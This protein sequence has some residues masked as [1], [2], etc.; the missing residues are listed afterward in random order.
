[1]R[2]RSNVPRGL[3]LVLLA[4]LALASGPAGGQAPKRGGILNA[5]LAEDP[6]GFS[7]HE[8]STISGVWPLSPCYS[9]LVLFD[10]LKPHESAETVVPELAERWSWQD[11]YR[12]L[13]FFLRKNVRW[14]DGQPFSAKDVKYTF[15]VVREA[16][17]APAKGGAFVGPALMSPP[18]G[19]W[20]L[21]DKELKALPGY[22]AAA[23]DK[24]EARRLL[25]SAGVAPGTLLKVDLVTRNFAIY[26]D[27]ASFVVDQLKQIGVEATLR[28][29]D[30][31]AWFPTL[32]RREFQIGANLTAGVVDDPDAY[33]FENYKCGSP[34]NYTDYCD[35]QV[36]RLIDA[37]SQ[38]STAPGASGSS[39]RS[40]ASSRP[41][42]R[43]R[44][45]AGARSTSRS[46]PT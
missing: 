24:S 14:H 7:I 20:G 11:N 44:C 26:V 40:S 42:W 8:S 22:R 25:A 23:Q 38:G 15:D 37:Q 6:P 1:M 4:A 13:V 35:E 43:G 10:P 12:N 27:L 3:C 5:M 33:F 31:A 16:R 19:A 28:Q 46:G 45:W 32:A 2:P 18:F 21:P 41:T 29:V 39:G 36:D 9:N 34:R 30:T 17:D